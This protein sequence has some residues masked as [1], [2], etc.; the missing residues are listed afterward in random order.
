MGLIPDLGTSTGHGY[1]QKKKKKAAYPI[2]YSHSDQTE[3]TPSIK[4]QNKK[5]PNTMSMLY[6]M[7][8]DT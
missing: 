1:S 5:Q 6:K 3:A 4:K 2:N 7:Q 8:Q